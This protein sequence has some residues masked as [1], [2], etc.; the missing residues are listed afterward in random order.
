MVFSSFVLRALAVAAAPST[1]VVVIVLFTLVCTD[2]LRFL[3]DLDLF[4]PSVCAAHPV[5]KKKS[6]RRFYEVVT[7]DWYFGLITSF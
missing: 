5:E 2:I 7:A 6:D 3:C 4:K 1:F